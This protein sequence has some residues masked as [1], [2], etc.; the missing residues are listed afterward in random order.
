MIETVKSI[1][2]RGDEILEPPRQDRG[3]L[4]AMS[5]ALKFW[6][7]EGYEFIDP[8][9]MAQDQDIGQV[10]LRLDKNGLLPFSQKGYMGYRNYPLESEEKRSVVSGGS[11][12]VLF[13][14]VMPD[15]A[16]QKM[17]YII[18]RTV[19]CWRAIAL[20]GGRKDLLPERMITMACGEAK[21][22]LDTVELGSCQIK[23]V[24][25]EET[26]Y[27]ILATVM[28]EPIWSNTWPE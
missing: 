17:Q 14:P 25:A 18:N 26:S 1:A 8:P 20:S 15:E 16:R 5:Q 4:E 24:E 21:L 19:V 12:L 22:M 6:L 27:H 13:I 3:G 28:S 2:E 7:R 10:F 9:E 23:R 11:D